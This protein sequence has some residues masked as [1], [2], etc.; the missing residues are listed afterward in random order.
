MILQVYDVKKYYEESVLDAVVW[1]ATF[2]SVVIIDIDIGLL[3]GLLLSFLVLYKKGYKTYS[4][5][6]GQV[7]ST[8]IYVDI[9]THKTIVELPHIKIFRFYG[10]VNFAT[11]DGFKKELYD[12]IG[13]DHRIIR[14]ASICKPQHEVV[15][16]NSDIRTL[17]ID[18][19]AIAHLDMSGYRTLLEIKKEMKLLDISIYL[20]NPSSCVYDLLTRAVKLKEESFECFPTIHDAVL[21]SNGL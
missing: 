1:I 8:D 5:M 16:L 21:Y 2:L 9:Q 17:I 3:I 13:I 6:L 18:L 4:C 12:N 20:A 10:S 15:R 11:R 19:S 7:P 14:R